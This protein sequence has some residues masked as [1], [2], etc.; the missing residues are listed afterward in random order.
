MC[1]NYCRNIRK[2]RDEHNLGPSVT[3]A[4]LDDACYFIHST[5]SPSFPGTLEAIYV[6]HGE[7]VS[8][9]VCCFQKTYDLDHELCNLRFWD[10]FLLEGRDV[11]VIVAVAIVWVLRDHLTSTYAN[12]EIVVSL[13]SSFF[14]PEDEDALLWLVERALDDKKLRAETNITCNRWRAEWR[15]LEEG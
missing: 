4:V 9:H 12:S 6:D 15:E 14:V 7:D 1:I 5:L 10:A 13:L 11:F 3:A 2:R 8:H